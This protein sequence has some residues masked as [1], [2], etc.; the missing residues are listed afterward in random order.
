LDPTF[1]CVGDYYSWALDN[2]KKTC[3]LCNDTVTTTPVPQ[4][5]T[6]AP[7]WTLLMKGVAGAPGPDLYQLW[8]SGQ[9]LN[10][11]IPQAQTLTSSYNG[12][13]KPDTSNHWTDFCFD[14]IKV[15][16]YNQG[17][18][19]AYI[20]FNATGADKNSWF[21]SDR[22]ISSSWT[23]LKTAAKEIFSMSGDANT[24]REFYA[25]GHSD[26]TDTCDSFGW[27]MIS[28]KQACFYEAGDKKPSFYY[29][30]GTSLAHWGYTNPG[31]GDVFAIQG[32]A[33]CT[34]SQQVTNHPITTP[35]AVCE[36][37]GHQYSQGEFWK[38]GC[39][40]NCTC[41]DAS[42]G[43][44]RCRNLCPQYTNLPPGCKLQK[45][46]GDCCAT[47]DC[48]SQLV[49]TIKPIVFVGGA[50]F[51]SY[52]GQYYTQDQTWNDG[53]SQS[54]TCTNADQG[55]YSC[56]AVCLNWN[57]L[58]A[59]CNLEDAPPGLCCQQPRCPS[60]IVITIPK[61][62]KDEYPGYQYV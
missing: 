46:P 38:D 1:Y 62:Y 47:P 11:N 17:I 50:A 15:G 29:A 30:P 55:M 59:V 27:M 45:V 56:R 54:C 41:E 40:Y 53:C 20:V 49:S 9:T 7:K 51:C 22:I 58:P 14:Q 44:Y 19:K 18:E 13:Y 33:A 24:G 26:P 48:G 31:T 52:K 5:V 16:I 25:S 60:G 8:H 39:Q 35:P 28:T 37:K 23:D 43:Y 2:C 61:A 4:T 42:I 6:S 3:K 21:T 36:Y 32:H 34:G 12:H 57:N 10:Q